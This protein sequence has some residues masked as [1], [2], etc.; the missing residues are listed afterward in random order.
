MTKKRDSRAPGAIVAYHRRPRHR[1]EILCHNHVVHP[2]SMPHGVNGFRWFTCRAGGEWERCPCG[3]RPD[4]GPHYASPD[5]VAW[6]REML[7]KLGGQDAFD[8]YCADRAFPIF[9]AALQTSE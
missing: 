4:L 8:R 3:W 9:R 6:T 5:H 2:S 7:K 1:G